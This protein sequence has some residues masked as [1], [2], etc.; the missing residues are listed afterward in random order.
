MQESLESVIQ[1]IDNALHGFRSVRYLAAL[2]VTLSKVLKTRF[3]FVSQQHTHQA[4]FGSTIVLA[5][6]GSKGKPMV[7]DLRLAPCR[8]VFGGQSITIPCN[9]SELYPGQVGMTAYCGV[10]L[11][12][13]G[14]SVLGVLALLSDKPFS[15]SATDQ[16]LAAFAL[17]CAQALDQLKAEDTTQ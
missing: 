11:L 7:Y 2:S 4:Y 5:E 13:A 10:P 6:N 15:Y 16:V 17:R 9:L 3:C 1:K 14:G 8:S 12:G